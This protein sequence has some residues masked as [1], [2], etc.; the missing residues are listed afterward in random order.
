MKLVRE[1]GWYYYTKAETEGG[2]GTNTL[3]PMPSSICMVDISY[4]FYRL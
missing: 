4:R 3:V 1:K 2:E